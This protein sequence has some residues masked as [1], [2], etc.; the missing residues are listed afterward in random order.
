LGEFLR[1]NYQTNEAIAVLEKAVQIA[2]ENGR[3]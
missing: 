2:P 1:Q 3:I